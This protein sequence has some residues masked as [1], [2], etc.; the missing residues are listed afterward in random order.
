MNPIPIMAPRYE[1]VD[2]GSGVIMHNGNPYTFTMAYEIISKIPEPDPRF[3]K[4]NRP[5]KEQ[6]LKKWNE[7]PPVP[8][9]YS[10]F[11]VL[12]NWVFDL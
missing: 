5:T 9:A 3:W 4:G 10:I 7:T 6:M 1:F 2:D 11:E 12:A 8:N